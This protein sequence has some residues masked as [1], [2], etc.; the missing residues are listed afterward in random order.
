MEDEGQ[1]PIEMRMSSM[2]Q[3]PTPEMDLSYITA[4]PSN[5]GTFTENQ[6]VRITIN[7]PTNAMVDLK[8]AYLKFKIKNTSGVAQFLDP[9]IGGV[10]AI[11]NFR[12]V[13]GTGALLEEVIHYNA[14]YSALNMNKNGD[15][16]ASKHNASE[17]ASLNPAKGVNVIDGNTDAE[18]VALKMTKLANNESKVITH[19]PAMGFF[20][21]DR[22]LPLGYSQGVVYCD[23]T[24][25]Q[26]A[27]AMICGNDALGSGYE[28]SNWELH[29][30]I[31][32][33]SVEFAQMFRSAMS[34]GVPIQIHSVSAQNTQQVIS[35]QSTGETTLT[36]ST[37]KRSVKS[38]MNCLRVNGAI[39]D[40]KSQ[41]VSGFINCGISEFNY[42]LQGQNIPAQRIKVDVAANG[43]DSGE[44]LAN[45][46]LALGHY[47][48]DLRG[49]CS[50]D[51]ANATQHYLDANEKTNELPSKAQ[52]SLDLESYN[53]AFAGKNLT[54]S[55][56]PVV[57]QALTTNK[58]LQD[59]AGNA[60]L[61]DLFVIHDVVYVL[62]G[63]GVMTASS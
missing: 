18:I 32:K 52:F 6:N 53:H 28:C 4:I 31:L 21:A 14:W 48:S 40:N 61:S 49:V 39:T 23:I 44:L 20:N 62:S 25:S 9:V 38:L 63:D 22:Y 5:G 30:P 17:G 54:G 11:E 46:Q 19:R 15:V 16:I 50:Y 60:V 3:P 33:P 8:R 37:R 56:L 12:V 35:A 29:I 13:G 59:T 41:S 55:G 47:S 34:A 26:N 7:C 57:F 36:F 2:P 45:Q 42:Q 27:T 24:L 1:T 10:S 43:N 51:Y 58:G